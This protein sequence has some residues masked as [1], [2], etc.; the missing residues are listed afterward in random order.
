M[1]CRQVAEPPGVALLARIVQM[2]LA[3][4]KDDLVLKER[5]LGQLDDVCRQVGASCVQED[6]K[7]ADSA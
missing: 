6:S 1:A 5:L 4:D 3:A 7:S 2:A